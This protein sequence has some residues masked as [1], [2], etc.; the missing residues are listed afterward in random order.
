MAQQEPVRRYDTLSFDEALDVSDV[1]RER[2][3]LRRIS[4]V[5]AVLTV[6]LIGGGLLL[7]AYPLDLQWKSSRE[8]ASQSEQVSKKVDGWPFPQARDQLRAATDYNAKLA[9]RGQPVLARRSIRSTSPTAA[10]RLPANP[11]PRHPRTPNTKVFWIP[12]TG[13]WERSRSRR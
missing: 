12:A 5:L 10:A 6:L 1:M 2:R 8:L 4:Q 3:T 11:T 13:S 7:G 9:A